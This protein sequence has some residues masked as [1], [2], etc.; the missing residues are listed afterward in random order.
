MDRFADTV[1]SYGH[2][3][4]IPFVIVNSRHTADVKAGQSAAS[5]SSSSS[6]NVSFSSGFSV[7]GG[8]GRF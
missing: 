1:R 2:G 7:G 5:S 6:T 8:S 3:N 4:Y